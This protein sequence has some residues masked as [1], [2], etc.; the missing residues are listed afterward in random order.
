M[1]D[2]NDKC[3]DIPSSSTNLG[4]VPQEYNCHGGANQRWTFLKQSNDAFVIRN[5]ASARCLDLAQTVWSTWVQQHA[6]HDGTNQQWRLVNAPGSTYQSGTTRLQSVR[7]PS[8]C[9]EVGSNGKVRAGSC[10]AT[11]SHFRLY[12]HPRERQVHMVKQQ[13]Q[14]CMDVPWASQS[15][16]T[17]IQ[18][19]PCKAFN[20]DNQAWEF[21]P[22]SDGRHYQIRSVNSG[23]CLR[24][25]AGYAR[26]R[27]CNS[28]DNNQRWRMRMMTDGSFQIRPRYSWS[29]RHCL[30]DSGNGYYQSAV[31]GCVSGSSDAYWY[32]E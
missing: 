18:K 3:L 26:Q 19:Y 8:R 15:T 27:G 32:V 17:A 16:G 1:L 2:S 4:V 21:E 11:D 22:T 20:D 5:E 24:Q 28:S 25:D 14:W 13:D 31:Y 29:G 6:C 7:D 9:V 30:Q 23:L 12:G 10:S